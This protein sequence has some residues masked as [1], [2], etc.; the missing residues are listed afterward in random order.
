MIT[1][2]GEWVLRTACIDAAGWPVGIKV[3]VNLSARQFNSDN[4][5]DVVMYALSRIRAIAGTAGTRNHRI[6]AD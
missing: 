2:I 4:L 1:Q 5:A 6:V 3:A